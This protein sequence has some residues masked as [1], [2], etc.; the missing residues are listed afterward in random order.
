MFEAQHKHTAENPWELEELF[1]YVRRHLLTQNQQCREDPEGSCLYRSP[2][3]E[4]ACAVGAIIPNALY[5]PRYEGGSL[6]MMFDASGFFIPNKVAALS[7]TRA[8][9]AS[10][11]PDETPFW[12]VLAA[13][14]DIHDYNLP[15]AWQIELDNLWQE[16]KSGEFYTSPQ[17]FVD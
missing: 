6:A 2:D 3:G 8:L 7:V 14:Q 10:G 4:R 9:I 17:R 12:K 16:I 13:L 1:E 15:H 11:V 5:E